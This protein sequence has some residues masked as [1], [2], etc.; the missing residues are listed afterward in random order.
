L[1]FQAVKSF[2]RAIHLYPA[3]ED[4][5]KEDLLWAKSLLD[6][7]H[8]MQAEI[9]EEKAGCTVT[10]ICDPPHK[11][12]EGTTEICDPPHKLTAV[13]DTSRSAREIS[14]SDSPSVSNE[15]IHPSADVMCSSLSQKLTDK[16]E[17]KHIS[18]NSSDVV[19][20]QRMNAENLKD[21]EDINV[22]K[23]LPHNYVRM[24]HHPS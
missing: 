9:T 8:R 2:S 5:W 17:F 3:D 23:K 10:E 22:M 11:L 14:Q 1:V 19:S 13:C 21:S 16:T 15:N 7:H 20:A 18:K 24:R 12:T 4:L 6:E